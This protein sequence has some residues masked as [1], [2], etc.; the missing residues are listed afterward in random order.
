VRREA[1]VRALRANAAPA[2]DEHAREP[3]RDLLA[4]LTQEE[5]DLVRASLDAETQAAW[6]S[7]PPWAR[8]HLQL[9]FGVHH[10]VE[11]VL[12]RTGLSAV[13]PPDDVHAMA[14]GPLAAGGDFWIADLLATAALG[15]GAPLGDGDRVLDFGSS[16]GRHLRVLQA[17][18]PAVHWMGCDPNEGAIRWAGEHLDGIEFFVSPQD[19]PLELAAGSLDAVFAVSVWSHF[20]AGAAE[21]WLEEMARVVRTGGVLVLT[22]QGTGSLSH[23]LQAERIDEDY[24]ARTAEALLARGH[25]YVEAFGLDGDWGVKH[26]EWGMAYMTLEWLAERALGAWTLERFEPRR[27]ADNQDL[28]ALR[29]R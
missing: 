20:G 4:R 24:A 2:Y 10:G 14:R 15:A 23:Y 16:S 5:L 12:R 28:V 19:P 6:D 18:R 21:R 26:P 29:R 27:I 22:T 13:M 25:A 9:I 3:T 17:W 7:A 8:E 1:I 11:P